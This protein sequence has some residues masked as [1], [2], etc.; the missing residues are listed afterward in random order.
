[1]LKYMKPYMCMIINNDNDTK[2]LKTNSKIKFI[3]VC[4]PTIYMVPFVAFF[5]FIEGRRGKKEEKVKYLG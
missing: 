3:K 1:M 4:V 2:I 5:F